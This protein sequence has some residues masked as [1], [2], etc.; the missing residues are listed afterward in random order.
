MHQSGTAHL[1]ML[2]I[3]DM[4]HVAGQPHASCIDEPHRAM[5]NDED[6]LMRSSGDFEQSA[7]NPAFE[8]MERLPARRIRRRIGKQ[9]Q[10]VVVRLVFPCAKTPFAQAFHRFGRNIGGAKS[11]E[12]FRRFL[13]APLRTDG[14]KIQP[15]QEAGIFF[16]KAPCRRPAFGGQGRST[17]P[18]AKSLRTLCSV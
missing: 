14:Q 13:C 6:V 16:G 3:S 9:G 8:D 7:Q 18:P 4:G 10:G 5:G 15:F 1:S 2:A 17:F 12:N 11:T